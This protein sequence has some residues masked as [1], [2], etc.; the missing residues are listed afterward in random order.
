MNFKPLSKFIDRIT[1]WRIPWAEVLV[2]YQNQEVFRYRS[3]YAD[4]EA[5]IP[6][7]DR[8]IIQLYSMTKIL[9][10]TA[11][12]QLVEKGEL[13]LND[14]LS[15]YLPEYREMSVKMTL[16]HG[17]AVFERAERP[18][19][20]RDLFTMSAGFSYDI[21]APSIQEV[22]RRTSGRAPTREV[23]AA[24]AKEPLL[25]EPGSRWCY[26]LCHDVLA[27]LVEV[28][29]GRRFSAY[30]REEITGPLGMHDTGFDLS[31]E[32]RSRLAPQYEYS[33]ALGKPIRKEGN[34]FRIGS[35]Y[36]SG[37]AGLF[38]TVN[39]YAVFLNTLTHQGT[40]ADG[41]RLLAAETVELMR[42]N[43]LTEA[44]SSHFSWSQL[45]GYGYG[46]GVRTHC[47]KETSGSLSPLGE[48]G[49]SGAAGS[50]AIMDPSSQLTVMYAQHMLNNQEPYVHP[51][52]RNLVYACL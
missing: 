5:C 33:D 37:G 6:I 11:A 23:A 52:L 34:D 28:V 10:C 2:L 45:A 42:M 12:L 15:D 39:D 24:I 47:S 19:R 32:D 25:F 18:I 13:L 29:D 49:W 3:G 38:S 20:V 4:M 31:D 40:S 17:K 14:P 44:T 1:D 16:P 43:H 50:L 7:H 27:A 41:V 9:T 21:H 46:L 35:E 48:F 36:E 51:R 26:S 22:V 8:Q 30:V